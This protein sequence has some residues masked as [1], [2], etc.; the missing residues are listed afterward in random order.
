MNTGRSHPSRHLTRWMLSSRLKALP[1][2]ATSTSFT[3][4]SVSLT[5]DERYS[6][7]FTGPVI[8]TR[9]V[10]GGVEYT[11]TSLRIS[12]ADWLNEPPWKIDCQL[13]L[14]QHELP[15]RVGTG[16]RQS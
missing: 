7:T 11:N 15:P 2:G 10:R 13:E 5:S 6:A 3:V 4:R 14:P 16:W 1:S 8:S 9:S 12:I